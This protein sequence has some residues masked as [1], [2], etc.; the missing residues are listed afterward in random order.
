MSHWTWITE[1]SQLLTLGPIWNPLAQGHPHAEFLSHEWILGAWQWRK[2]QPH[3]QL[4]ILQVTR[5]HRTI[6]LFP[7]L[8]QKKKARGLWVKYLE[9]IA[10]PDSQ[11]C[12]ALV[13]T[14]AHSMALWALENALNTSPHWDCLSLEKLAPTS[15]LKQA[16]DK[17]ALQGLAPCLEAYDANAWVNVD[18]SFEQYLSQKSRRFKKTLNHIENKLTQ[19]GP[20]CVEH[21]PSS[22]P[23]TPHQR[24]E[25]F[26]TVVKLSKSSWKNITQT[27][28]DQPGPHA[29]IHYMFHQGWRDYHLS[30]W[31][32]RLHHKPIAFELQLRD[33]HHVYGLRS[34]FDPEYA[35]LSPGSYL[36]KK[37]LSTLCQQPLSRRY[38][39]GPGDNPY[40]RKYLSDRLPLFRCQAYARNLKGHILSQME[41]RWIPWLS[42]L[43]NKI[44]S[45]TQKGVNTS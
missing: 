24:R 13:D 2:T 17:G 44:S 38:Y 30:V 14:N 16:L 8:I 26:N 31:S 27:T 1:E 37:I 29:F 39:L 21:W 40:K 32:L 45:L 34:D 12:D 4:Q 5:D 18:Q 42:P 35:E 25:V 43:K 41:N 19:Q 20:L 33:T 36:N 7:F 15:W 23:I 22:V 3:T 9:F 11:F 10:I 6:A 28:F